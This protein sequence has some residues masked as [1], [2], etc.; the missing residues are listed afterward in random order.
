MVPFAQHAINQLAINHAVYPGYQSAVTY[1]GS[2]A[3][4]ALRLR[5]YTSQT[6][7]LLVGYKLNAWTL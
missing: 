6:E 4:E 3:D 1:A 2:V 5:D 7:M